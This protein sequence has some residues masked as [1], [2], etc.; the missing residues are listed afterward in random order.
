M[1]IIFS[2]GGS[3]SRGLVRPSSP[4]LTFTKSQDP[5]VHQDYRSK[6]PKLSSSQPPT[7]I[8]P[9]GELPGGNGNNRGDH[10]VELHKELS[11]KIRQRRRSHSMSSRG[12]RGILYFMQESK[13]SILIFSGWT[14]FAAGHQ[15]H[16]NLN[17]KFEKELG[18]C[19]TAAWEI[20]LYY[21]LLLVARIDY[22]ENGWLSFKVKLWYVYFILTQA[23]LAALQG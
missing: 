9:E 8:L 17:W 7:M 2:S 21:S 18:L 20:R 23:F 13:K 14:D 22:I 5:T 3:N 6:K 4:T 16:I 12:E 19:K 11:E 1:N 15:S 10:V